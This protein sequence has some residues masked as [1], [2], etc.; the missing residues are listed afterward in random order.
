M[1]PIMTKITAAALAVSVGLGMGVVPSF[2]DAS[3]GMPTYNSHN[4]R[5]GG[6]HYR[7]HRNWRHDR[8]WRHRHHRHHHRYYRRH[9]DNGAGIVGGLI[10]GAIIGGIA[11]NAMGNRG[12]GNAHVRWCY[13][14]YRS[15]RA[16]DNTY[17]PYH[18]PRRQC[19]SPY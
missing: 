1:K 14:H 6:H 15:Y 12:G 5:H 9:Y 10:T 4:Y 18:G 16:S 11:A 8:S 13:D 2:A 3:T 7:S 17:Q 19:V